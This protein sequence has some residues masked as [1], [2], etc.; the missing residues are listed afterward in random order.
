MFLSCDEE[1]DKNLQAILEQAYL[2]CFDVLEGPTGGNARDM[3][4]SARAD[5]RKDEQLGLDFG[6]IKH[7]QKTGC[8]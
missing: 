5:L 6:N 1:P 2:L 8:E 3:V 7:D 4:N